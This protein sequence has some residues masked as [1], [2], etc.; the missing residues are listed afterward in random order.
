[1][2]ERRLPGR[3]QLKNPWPGLQ[4]RM[5]LAKKAE[6]ITELVPSSRMARSLSGLLPEIS[7]SAM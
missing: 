2:T 1:V 3:L 7:I 5:M 6:N 4:K